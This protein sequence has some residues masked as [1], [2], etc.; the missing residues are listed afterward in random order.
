MKANKSIKYILP[1]MTVLALAMS[2]AYAADSAGTTVTG[3]ITPKLYYFNY[4]G[5]PGAGLTPY[6]QSYSGQESWSGDRDDGFYADVDLSLTLSGEQGDIL[7]LERQ[8][9]GLDNHRG[10]IKGG[11]G[12]IGFSG[13]Y[14]H[15]RSNTGG[16]DYVNRPG[17]AD[18][19]TDPA[20]FTNTAHTNTGFL[21]K[22]NDDTVGEPDYHTE[23]TRYGVGVKFKPGLLGKGTSL[24]LNFDGYKRDGN[25]FATWVAG[26]GDFTNGPAAVPNN[27]PETTGIR[28]P[29]RWRGYDKPIDEKMG[30][31]SLNFT[32]SP[33]GMFQ[34]AYDG[35]YEKFNN[36]SRTVLLGDFAG[37]LANGV[38]VTDPDGS[39]GTGSA[40][41]PMHFYPDSTLMTHAVR[42]SKTFGNTAV[43]A[44]YGMSKLEQDSFHDIQ[45]DAGYVGK[46]ST[47]NAFLNLS[48]RLSPTV[49]LEGYV[50]YYNRDNDSPEVADG[51]LDRAVRDE[52]GVR[53]ANIESLTYGLSANFRGLPAKSSLTAG[54]KREDSDREL[55]WNTIPAA[56]NLGQWPTA[57]LLSEETV[58]DEIYLKWVA[59]PLP[60]M[61]LRITPSYIWADKTALVTLPEKSLNLKTALSYAMTDGMQ[62]N[63]YYNF[64]DKKNGNQSFTDTNKPGN[65][66]ITLTNEYSQKADDTLHAA[67][68][69]LNLVPMERV[70]A[71]VS[72]DW[73]QNDFETYFFGTNVRRFETNIV[74]DPRGTSAFKVD[75]WSLSLN[76]DYQA[77]DRLRLN[78][79]YTFSKSDGDLT[80][81]ST[82]G[83]PIATGSYVVNDKIDHTLHSLMLGANYGLKKNMTLRGGYVYDKYEDD[84]YSA[85]SGGVHTL[86]AGVSFAL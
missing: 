44:G 46:I 60:G 42:A 32:A 34:F 55:W 15:Y 84:A 14:S 74:F 10:S 1:C 64:K 58:S 31:M 9:F 40:D 41:W 80:T 48:H 26:N 27:D 59:R 53:I 37:F 24:S 76:G 6:L 45:I 17:T 86:M 21:S 67:G 68:V 79:G 73:V 2:Q 5:G 29:Q 33:A 51:L 13:Y 77:S 8:G 30:R 22:F 72:L 3:E 52:W 63:A 28:T 38:T 83:F 57:S 25:K 71:S 75:T 54:W 23:R 12:G 4:T 61:T 7:S 36:Q 43:A 39:L 66:V 62:L 65:G 47:E 49:G 82:I 81:T 69:S 56:P 19:P 70:N 85:L 18:N 35:S 78:A 11:S 20:Y 50:K 16:V